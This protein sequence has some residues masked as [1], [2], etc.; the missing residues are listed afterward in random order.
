MKPVIKSKTVWANIVTLLLAL[1]MLLASPEI[2]ALIPAG[3]MPFLLALNAGLNIVL[4]LYTDT[5]LGS[6]SDGPE[7]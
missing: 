1:P 3:V 7:A 4:R 6:P 2:A 5:A